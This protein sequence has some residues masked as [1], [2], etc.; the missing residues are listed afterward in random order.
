ME[1]HHFHPRVIR[2]AHEGVGQALGREGFSRARSALEDEVLLASQQPEHLLQILGADE[3][4]GQEALP[5][6]DVGDV[7]LISVLGA[8][9]RVGGRGRVRVVPVPEQRLELGRVVAR[10]LCDSLQAHCAHTPVERPGT[11]MR[12]LNVTHAAVGGPG[13][14]VTELR[15][16]DAS[17]DDLGRTAPGVDDVAGTHRAGEVPDHSRRACRSAS[18]VPVAGLQ[19]LDDGFLIRVAGGVA[20]PIPVERHDPG[21]SKLLPLPGALARDVEPVA[22]LLLLGRLSI[23]IRRRHRLTHDSSSSPVPAALRARPG[24]IVVPAHPIGTSRVRAP[25][26]LDIRCRRGP[27]SCPPTRR[28]SP[29]GRECTPTRRMSPSRSAAQASCRSSAEQCQTGTRP[30]PSP[31]RYPAP[32]QRPSSAQADARSTTMRSESLPT[33][34]SRVRGASRGW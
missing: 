12:P 26:G 19:R 34:G 3:H 25:P 33:S 32:D 20:D 6:V 5:R 10:V 29:T 7:G 28:L 21:R 1:L 23:L 11:D 14:V 15:A 24:G 30:G 4:L 9:G 8:R 18:P 16:D 27:D 22:A 31:G 13:V 2:L 17:P